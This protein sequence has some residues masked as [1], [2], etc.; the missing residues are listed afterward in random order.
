MP[1][2]SFAELAAQQTSAF[3]PSLVGT[4]S[5]FFTVLALQAW[6]AKRQGLPRGKAPPELKTDFYWWL[7]NPGFRV[8]S[9]FI[10]LG[11]VFVAAYLIGEEFHPGIFE[12]YGPVKELP[13]WLMLALLFVLTD[14]TSYWSHRLC[15]SVPFLWKFHAIHHSP[16]MV[17]WTSVARLHPVNELLTYCANILP[18]IAL[19]FPAYALGPFIPVI[20]I[21]ALYSHAKWNHSLGPFRFVFTGPLYHRW[22]HTFTHEGGN[23]NFSGVFAFWDMMFGTYYMPK[24]KVPEVFGLDGEEIPENFWT[25]MAYPFRSA[26]PEPAAT[27]QRATPS[28]VPRSSKTSDAVA[29]VE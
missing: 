13:T 28:I 4:M 12:G 9:R 22:H 3:V 26:K 16:T 18:A 6:R 15:H 27:A 19:G 2:W 14:F 7:V 20:A 10:I 21:Y 23:K 17:R 8:V 11:I 24:G 1:E 25:Q 5:M 29:H